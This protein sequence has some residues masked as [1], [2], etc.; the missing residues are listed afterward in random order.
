MKIKSFFKNI[1]ISII[2]WYKK[3]ISGMLGH[4][5]IYFPTCSEYAVEAIDKYGIIKGTFMAIK[6]IL[7][8]N[9]F[10]KGGYDKV[11]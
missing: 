2:K 8:C 11:K 5:C 7:K 3:H 10:A 9:P 4:N 6:R 1:E